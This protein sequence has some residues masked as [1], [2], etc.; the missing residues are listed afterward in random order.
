VKGDYRQHIINSIEEKDD[1]PFHWNWGSLCDK[2]TIREWF[3]W[4]I[5]SV[6][7]HIVDGLWLWFYSIVLKIND[8]NIG[9]I[10]Y[11]LGPSG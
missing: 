7:G 3:I 2:P 1:N 11:R 10:S 6:S 4:F 5:L 9:N 8:T